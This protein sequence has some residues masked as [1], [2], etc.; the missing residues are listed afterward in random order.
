MIFVTGSFHNPY[1]WCMSTIHD[2]HVRVCVFACLRVCVVFK[3]MIYERI[4]LFTRDPEST[5]Q[6][7]QFTIYYPR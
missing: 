2:F 7:L 1:S 4:D 3:T 6:N 5:M